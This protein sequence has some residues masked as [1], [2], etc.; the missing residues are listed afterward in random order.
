[1]TDYRVDPTLDEPALKLMFA[2]VMQPDFYLAR[3]VTGI[4]LIE[5]RNIRADFI[6]KPRPHLVSAGFDNEYIAVEIKSPE[7]GDM[8]RASQTTWQCATYVQSIFW[9]K[10][11]PAFGLVFPDVATFARPTNSQDAQRLL[12]HIGQFMNVGFL[13][14]RTATDWAIYIGSQ[15]YFHKGG[16]KTPQNL[17]KRYIG[18]KD[19]A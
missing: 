6:I 8:W 19:A 18:N 16:T 4:H 13:R 2:R 1:M 9:G 15:R 3:E 5:K 14:L 11:R 10:V 7:G 12:E 17:T